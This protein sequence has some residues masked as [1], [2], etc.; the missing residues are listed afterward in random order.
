ML[1][2]TF[3]EDTAVTLNEFLRTVEGRHN[4]T[5][6]KGSGHAF[7]GDHLDE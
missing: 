5:L 7:I 3:H 6:T 4:S 1:R 2:D